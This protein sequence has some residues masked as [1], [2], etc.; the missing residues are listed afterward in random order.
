MKRER[1]FLRIILVIGMLIWSANAFGAIPGDVD[2][3]GEVDLRDA[4]MAIQACTE[5]LPVLSGVDPE[6]GN[7]MRTT[8]CTV[9]ILQLESRG[10]TVEHD[11]L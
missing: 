7:P 8:S 9:H 1:T 11:C 3:S 5:M 2:G 6:A 4:V 10:V